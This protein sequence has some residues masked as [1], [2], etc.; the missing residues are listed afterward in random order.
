M[1]NFRGLTVTN[2]DVYRIPGGVED[3]PESFFNQNDVLLQLQ[4][5]SKI[6][7]FDLNPK[8]DRTL[9]QSFRKLVKRHTWIGSGQDRHVADRVEKINESIFVIFSWGFPAWVLI[10]TEEV[11]T[12]QEAA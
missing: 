4:Y 10:K 1:A 11:E 9:R 12:A 3:M 8:T 7:N 2:F 5:C 6:D